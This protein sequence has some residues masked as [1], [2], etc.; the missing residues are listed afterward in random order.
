[1]SIDHVVSVAHNMI[2]VILGLTVRS[3]SEVVD[4]NGR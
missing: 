1:V 4:E 2:N 3:L